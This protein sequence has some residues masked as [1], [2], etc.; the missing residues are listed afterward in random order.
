[1]WRHCAHGRG[2]ARAGSA[3]RIG[4]AQLGK[5][6]ALARRTA[7]A[8]DRGFSGGGS[9]SALGAGRA[10]RDASPTAHRLRLRMF[11]RKKVCIEGG[12]QQANQHIERSRYDRGKKCGTFY[13]RGYVIFP[14]RRTIRFEMLLVDREKTGDR[15]NRNRTRDNLVAE[16]ST[17]PHS[18]QFNWTRH[19]RRAIGNRTCA[20]HIEIWRDN[21]NRPSASA[22]RTGCSFM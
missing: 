21:L 1:V 17:F 13:R 20:Y 9:W 19:S 7:G 3:N 22:S 8:V 12:T 16:A 18:G 15:R 11:G 10:G 5:R 14:K 2:R 6:G 4:R